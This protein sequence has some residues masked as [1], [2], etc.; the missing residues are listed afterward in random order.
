NSPA[1][2]AEPL[3]RRLPTRGPNSLPADG[4]Q[5]LRGSRGPYFVLR[6]SGRMLSSRRS[7]MGPARRARPCPGDRRGPGPPRRLRIEHDREAAVIPAPVGIVRFAESSRE[8]S[9]GF[10]RSNP[11]S[12]NLHRFSM[13]W[14]DNPI[15]DL[16]VHPGQLRTGYSARYQPILVHPDSI[17]R[18]SAI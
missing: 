8:R 17:A 2:G 14:G 9:A 16:R 4:L 10:Q 13:T 5:D 15:T 1:A 6:Y 11:E 7:R 3:R 18:T 12:L